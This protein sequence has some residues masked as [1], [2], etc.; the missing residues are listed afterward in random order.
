MTPELTALAIAGLVQYAQFFL[1]AV[2]TNL[3]V[4]PRWTMGPRDEPIDAP[5]KV[6]RLNRA[7]SNH[8]EGL[9]LFT[10]AVVVITLA[11]KGTGL[12]ATCAWIYVASRILYVPAYFFGLSPWRTFAWAPGFIATLIMLL[13]VVI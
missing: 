9:V 8:F 10:I 13:S 12:T 4:S 11:D 5:I 2:V 6:G 3:T 1:L 7:L